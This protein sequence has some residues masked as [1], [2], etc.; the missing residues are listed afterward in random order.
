MVKA[1]SDNEE[2]S[3][4]ASVKIKRKLKLIKIKFDEIKKSPSDNILCLQI[5]K[6][7]A[8]KKG[9]YSFLF[10]YMI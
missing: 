2:A 1:S 8:I 7:R 9:F 4:K 5:H 3:I 10:F 6:L